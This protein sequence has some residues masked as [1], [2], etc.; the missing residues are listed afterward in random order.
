MQMSENNL[1]KELQISSIMDHSIEQ[2]SSLFAQ[3][4]KCKIGILGDF[5]IDAYWTL[6]TGARETSIET[7]RP[8]YAVKQ[9]R[10]SLGGAGNI[11]ANLVALGVKRIECTG[12]IGDDIFGRE[13]RRLLNK[14]GAG[15]ENLLPQTSE[16]Q[17]PVYSK[18]YWGNE[19]LDRID[20]GRFN[21]IMKDSEHKLLKKLDELIL[22]LDVLIINHQLPKS[23]YS[24]KIWD[25]LLTAAQKQSTCKFLI[26]FRHLPSRLVGMWVKLNEDEAARYCG[27][28]KTKSID[29]EQCRQFAQFIHAKSTKPVIITRGAK[30]VL[31]YDGKAFNEIP[32]IHITQPTDIVGAGDTSLATLAATIAAGQPIRAAAQLANYAAAI[33]IQKLQQTG[34][35]SP[36]E[37]LSMIDSAQFVHRPELAANMA[38]AQYWNNTQIEIVNPNIEWGKIKWAIFDH[39]GTISVLR[40]GWEPI[41]EKMMLKHILGNERDKIAP[42]LY[43]RIQDQVRQYVL[44]SA[45]MQTVDQMKW[46]AQQIEDYG[47][48]DKTKILTGEAYKDLFLDDLLAHIKDRTDRVRKGELGVDDVTV[49]GAAKCVEAFT[50]QG[51]NLVLLSGTDH[52]AVIEE[53]NLLGYAHFFEGRIYGALAHTDAHSK[54]NV[55]KKIV[56]ENALTGSELLALGDG[57]NE[58]RAVKK[59]GGI[60]IGIASDE[61]RR[62]GLNHVKRSRLIQAG[63]DVIISDYAQLSELIGLIWG[64]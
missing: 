64:K 2:F 23:I 25:Y 61:V 31:A 56:A 42:E 15:H 14:I 16:W 21:Q 6:E 3:F 1:E 27:A 46:L 32:G 43:K 9:Q 12:L 13:M 8:T 26:D 58:I 37:I 24:E 54:Q 34:T 60:A 44:H 33:S 22:K 18:P 36:K 11:V 20:F 53:A 28:E 4:P 5:C 39:D 41:M 51:I 57:S 59:L 47:F 55:M 49:K 35:A 52:E 50:D 40:E 48:V 45:G 7:N 10:Y 30:G 38:K 29:Q 17:T 63:A 19:E 62:Y